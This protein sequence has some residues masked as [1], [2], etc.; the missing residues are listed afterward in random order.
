MRVLVLGGTGM[1]G[2][3]LLKSGLKSDIEF[4]AVVRNKN[5][6]C[7]KMPSFP[8]DNIYEI[9]DINNFKV[10]SEILDS[11][12]P[13]FVIN[14]I[15]IIKQSNFGKNYIAN[16]EINSL[17]P[18]KLANLCESRKIRL[19]HISTDCVFDGAKG[20]YSL[21]DKPNA[22]DLYGQSKYLGEIDYGN[23]ITLRTS[24][25]GHEISGNN[26]G[27]LEW[28]LNSQVKVKGYDKAIFSGV[29][30]LELSKI[31]INV[32]L[33]KNSPSGL[34]QLSSEPI[35]KFKL[36]ELIKKVYRKDLEILPSDEI[37]INRSLDGSHFNNIFKYEVSAWG[38]MIE[39]LKA[40]WK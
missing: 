39:E 35:N 4:F 15:G 8:L 10:L 29:T 27:L 33:K 31:L 36:L 26:Y 17:L 30:T 16:I 28:F 37:V 2:F 13:E 21:N 6:M 20:S 40:E 5:L 12:N 7:E 25:I 19:I 9:D 23:H 22:I 11:I 18:H 24:I 32:V 38:L 34:F 14:A 1:L 3:Q